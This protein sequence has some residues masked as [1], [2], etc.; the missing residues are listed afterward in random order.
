VLGVELALDRALA[1]LVDNAL[2]VAP[3]GSTI[4]IASGSE[5]GWA[6]LAVDDAGPG[7]QLDGE[8]MP[9]GL[10]LSIVERVV[11]A[12]GGLL[13][14]YTGSHGAGTTMVMWLPL[15]GSKTA[16]PNNSP[17]TDT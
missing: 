4:R 5:S 11:D 7:L 15:P 12:H 8:E 2:K 16:Q 14:N 3:V 1:N 9:I 10:G 17:L 6:Y 13:A